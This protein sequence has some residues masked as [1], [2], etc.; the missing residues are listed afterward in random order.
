M[1]RQDQPVR[2]G[3]VLLVEDT[4]SLQMLYRTVLRKAGFPPLS[5][6]TGAEA[7]E[8]FAENLPRVVLLDLM[9]PDTDGLSVMNEMLRQQPE[10]RVIV[11]S[12][13]GSISNAVEAT[14]AGA[15]DFLVK[16]L[17][18]LR[19]VSAVANAMG[20]SK[21]RASQK[22]VLSRDLMT[23]GDR[24]FLGRSPAIRRVREQ[25]SAI[26]GS[27]AP[28]F[29]LGESGTGK[30]ACAE[31]IHARS[32]RARGK[33]VLISCRGQPHA[34]LE[35]TL[36]GPE[37]AAN[38]MVGGALARAHGSSLY[39]ENPE[40]LPLPLQDRLLALLDSGRIT[41]VGG[42]APQPLDIRLICSAP[43]DPREENLRDDLFYRLFVI[44]LHMPPLRARREDIP[45]LA[46]SLLGEV[47][48]QERKRFTRLS[49]D[50]LDA[51]ARQP[52]PGNLRELANVLR[53]AVV[54]NS[55]PI[56]T[57]AMLEPHL[58]A[59]PDTDQPAPAPP[60]DA[61][62]GLTMAE[63]E[64]RVI[65]AA[66]ERHGGSVPQAARELDIAPSTIYRKRDSW[67]LSQG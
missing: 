55:G 11:I 28:V 16:P 53:Q 65:E 9:L 29:I 52:W 3:D 48:Q 19:L 67:D 43:R 26:A 10:T 27:L 14:R 36:F 57:R 56:L 31:M 4:P 12:A 63:I 64:R 8:L 15:H 34:V 44:A 38:G 2:L 17:G 61:L 6:M 5:A 62:A 58:R 39:L 42:S 18:D 21:R 60:E 47:A 7:L 41:P 22:P 49:Q 66:I 32:P 46:Q 1:T 54:L 30:C 25:T 37:V 20:A 13:N 40:A 35:Q 59:A 33:M 50:A 24:A 23:F 51:L 45:F